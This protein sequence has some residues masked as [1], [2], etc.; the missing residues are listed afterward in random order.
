MQQNQLALHKYKQT[1]QT[2]AQFYK[3][4]KFYKNQQKCIKNIK[5]SGWKCCF[6]CEKDFF[7]WLLVVKVNFKHSI[8]KQA[9]PESSKH[10]QKWWIK[11]LAEWNCLFKPLNGVNSSATFFGCE[12]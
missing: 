4:V 6:F 3:L 7:R 8:I 9:M 1:K 2:Q 11:K 10:N 5:N 12:M